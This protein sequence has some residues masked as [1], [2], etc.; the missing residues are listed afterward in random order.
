MLVWMTPMTLIS[1]CMD[2]IN[3]VWDDLRVTLRHFSI[4]LGRDSSDKAHSQQM[5]PAH[6]K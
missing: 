2:P 1:I 5:T 4:T 6:F 3:F